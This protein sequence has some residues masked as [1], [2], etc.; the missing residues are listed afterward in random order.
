ML[1]M[2]RGELL[3]VTVTARCSMVGSLGNRASVGRG[4]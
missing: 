3:M 2:L 4:E 1:K